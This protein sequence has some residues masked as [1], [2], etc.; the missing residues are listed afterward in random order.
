[1]H[2]W[3]KNG[4]LVWLF[5][6]NFVLSKD[7]A[8]LSVTQGNTSV[9]SL[10]WNPHVHR[11]LNLDY[12]TPPF[13]VIF[14][15]KNYLQRSQQ[16][17]GGG[18]VVQKSSRRMKQWIHRHRDTDTQTMFLTP[19]LLFHHPTKNFFQGVASSL[20]CG[21][22]LSYLATLA[23]GYLCC[24]QRTPGCHREYYCLGPV[25]PDTS[26]L[27]AAASLRFP[28]SQSHHPNLACQGAVAC[29]KASTSCP[30]VVFWIIHSDKL[31]GCLECW[32]F[33]P[34]GIFCQD[35]ASSPNPL[36]FSSRGAAFWWSN[37]AEKHPALYKE[38]FRI[39]AHLGNCQM[40]VLVASYN[41]S[42]WLRNSEAK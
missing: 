14:L 18:E 22:C 19:L 36:P 5:M 33:D 21:L 24:I 4:T 42:I 3:K 10:K 6:S 29:C 2:G 9:F 20:H 8:Q 30:D 31:A 40:V 7:Q 41:Y 11:L 12:S 38:R 16:A 1:M 17:E 28:H 37:P 23:A 13:Y 34:R 26:C 15:M 39:T 32:G 35:A 25:N 27:D